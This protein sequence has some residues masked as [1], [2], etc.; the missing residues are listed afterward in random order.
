MSRITITRPDDWHVHLRDGE[1]M[2]SIVGMSAKQMGRAI[3]MPNLSPPITNTTLAK[4]YYARIIDSLPNE[5]SFTPLMVLYLTDNTTKVEILEANNEPE[6]YA[7]K[8]YPAGAT[9]NSSNGVTNIR[10]IYPVLDV[11]Q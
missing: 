5:T 4:D 9:T 6:I 3:I 7:A 11:M 8:L 10:K 2:R 1:A